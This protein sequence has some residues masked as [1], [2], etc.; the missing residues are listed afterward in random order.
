MDDIDRTI[1]SMLQDDADVPGKAI[2]EAVDLSISAVERRINKLKQ[3]GAIERIAAVVSPK[4]VDRTLSVIVEL[5]IQNEHRHTLQ[6]LQK[7]LHH[8]PEVQSCWYV[9]GDM[10]YVLIVAVRD[11]EEYNDFIERLM[12]EQQAIVR[13]YKSLIALKTIKRGLGIRVHD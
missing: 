9:T 8:A 5:E 11:L 4:A 2:A 10:D 13:K 12:S 7:W 6:Q 3:E 1:L